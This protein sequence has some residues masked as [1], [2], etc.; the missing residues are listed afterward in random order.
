MNLLDDH[1]V[2]VLLCGGNGCQQ[3]GTRG[4]FDR[5]SGAL[6]IN[7][8][9]KSRGGRVAPAAA[10]SVWLHVEVKTDHDLDRRFSIVERRHAF[11]RDPEEF[12]ANLAK[13]QEQLRNKIT[14]A[15]KS[16]GSVIVERPLL[17]QIAQ[18]CTEL[19]IDGHR[20]ELTITRAGAC[21]RGI[22]RPQDGYCRGCSTRHA[23]EFAPQAAAGSA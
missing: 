21:A 9:R 2:D 7:W 20:G 18:L 15:Q 8:L 13:D 16:A 5:A 19:K 17:R 10:G 11:E 22:R 1:L 23:Y 14:R 4:Y 3:G 6:R 12:C